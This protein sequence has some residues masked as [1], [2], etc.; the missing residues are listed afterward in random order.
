[1][2]GAAG[3]LAR[4]Y[5]VLSWP[6][7][8]ALHAAGACFEAWLAGRGGS[9]SGEDA[10]ALAQVRAFL[11]AHSESR[12]TSLVPPIVGAEPA[13]PEAG[14]TINR[15]GYR[16]RAS[17]GD[18]ERWEYLVLP[19]TW[20]T[21]VCKGLNPKRTADLLVSLRFLLGTTPRDRSTVISIPGD[22]R[23]RVYRVS[24]A[25]LGDD[26]AGEGARNGSR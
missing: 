12:F 22:G 4:D 5:R 23:Q 1:L 25:I 21:E 15:A 16:R 9:G 8:K 13:L 19:E 18:G 6:E 17:G 2:I 11:E 24:G 14:H 20:K 10:A 7:G 26:D 3:E